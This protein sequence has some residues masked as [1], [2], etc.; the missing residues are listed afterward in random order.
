VQCTSIRGGTVPT[1]PHI[2]ARRAANGE[3][4][5]G[6]EGGEENGEAQEEEVGLRRIQSS[7]FTLKLASHGSV[8]V[9]SRSAQ[10]D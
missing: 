7:A 4:E 2:V 1:S 3:E 10:R 5:K 8:S 9:R 6:E